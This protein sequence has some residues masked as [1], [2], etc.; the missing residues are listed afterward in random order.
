[1]TL[2]R[3]QIKKTLYIENQGT[4]KVPKYTIGRMC[5]VTAESGQT[6]MEPL[7]RDFISSPDLWY[8]DAIEYGDGTTID[9]AD[10]KG[11]LGLTHVMSGSVERPT[12]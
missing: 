4:L 1:M 11:I 9:R 8:F 12:A 3:E 7:P 10:T 5:R 6:Y 2:E